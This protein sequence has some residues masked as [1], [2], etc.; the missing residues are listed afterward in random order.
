MLD[1]SFIGGSW[2]SVVSRD[3]Y[4]VDYSSSPRGSPLKDTSNIQDDQ[5]YCISRHNPNKTYRRES[6][7]ASWKSLKKERELA[8]G[9]RVIYVDPNTYK[10]YYG[11]NQMKRCKSDRTAN[12][13]KVPKKVKRAYSVLYRY[14]PNEEKVIKEYKYQLPK[15]PQVVTPPPMQRSYSEPFL[16]PEAVPKK[17]VKR[18][19]TTLLN[20]KT[21]FFN[22]FSSKS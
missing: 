9:K 19:F 1:K 12:V 13:P 16:R 4:E 5:T 15:E 6:V 7:I 20:I 11:R 22:I 17:K 14:D 21:K 10:D 3:D 18:S 2:E 8:L